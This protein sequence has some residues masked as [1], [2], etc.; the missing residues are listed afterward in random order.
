MK[1]YKGYYIDQV[2][3]HSEE[4]ID[5]YI[6]ASNIAKMQQFIRMMGNY[7]D[8]EMIMAASIEADKIAESLVKEYGMTWDEIEAAEIAA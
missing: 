8:P 5:A 6:K 7:N 3:F 1:Q 4:E 2:I